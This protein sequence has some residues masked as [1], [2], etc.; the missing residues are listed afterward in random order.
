MAGVAYPMETPI[1]VKCGLVDFSIHTTYSGSAS[2]ANNV[3]L[4]KPTANIAISNFA[5]R[6][7]HVISCFISLIFT[8]PLGN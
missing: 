6:F 3:E 2:W 1:T 8:G 7:E 5:I 4:E